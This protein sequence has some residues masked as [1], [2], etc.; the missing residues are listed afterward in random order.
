MILKN[1]NFFKSNLFRNGSIYFII[2]FVSKIIPFMIIPL[3]TKYLT[4]KEYGVSAIYQ[5]YIVLFGLVIGFELNRYLEIYY[6]KVSSDKF[7][8]YIST[9]ISA[10]FIFAF[11]VFFISFIIM[12]YIITISNISFIWIVIIPF[13]IIFKFIFTIND[14]LLRNE[15]N[16]IVYGKYTILEALIY[17]LGSLLLAYLFHN[18]T[19]K[20]YSFILT[21]IILGTSSYIRLRKFY[22][23]KFSIDK[24]ILKKALLYSAP[25]VF[26]LNLANIIFSNSDKIILLHFYNYKIVGIFAV[27]F[28]FASITGFVTDSFMKAWIPIFYKKLKNNDKN[29]NKESFL[30]FISLGIITII[31]IF[32][33]KIIMPYMIDIKYSNAIEIMPYI[34]VAYIFRIGEQLLLYYIN[35][36]EIT[37]SLYGIIVLTIFSNIICAY[38]FVQE[39]GI[40]GMAIAINMF[41][42]LKIIY[43]LSLLKLKRI[44]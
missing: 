39:Y 42:I 11:I 18:W 17:S 14:S 1:K 25:F 16:P 10:V 19:S 20:A 41:F 35:F 27:A 29:V 33:L 22:N 23:I 9:I 40:I 44:L 31:V 34:A 12:N 8:D 4:P 30:I 37:N 24:Q 28:V 38:F 6:F 13:I 7:K 36:Y 21:M 5:M 3:M 43:Y 26:G 32:I 15:E 2:T